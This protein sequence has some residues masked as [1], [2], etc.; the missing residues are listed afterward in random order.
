MARLHPMVL[1]SSR[2]LLY[3]VIAV[4][5]CGRPADERYLEEIIAGPEDAVRQLAMNDNVPINSY[6]V[7]AVQMGYAKAL[8]MVADIMSEWL[9]RWEQ[10]L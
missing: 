10:C 1:V 6:T 7:E 8:A 4:N 2:T 3:M 9:E 5:M